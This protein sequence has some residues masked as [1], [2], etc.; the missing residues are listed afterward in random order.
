MV[1]FNGTV[2]DTQEKVLDADNRGFLYGDSVFETVKAVHQT[3]LF[4]E[5]HY[6]RLMASMRLM[7]M[8]IPMSFTLEFLRSELQK[9]IDPNHSHAT[10][11]RLSVFREPGGRYF[12]VSNE[13]QYLIVSE[14]LDVDAFVA[15]TSD[16]Q[17]DLFKD[18]H[19]TSSLLSTLKTNNRSLNV[20]G[21][22]YAQDN[23]L[24]NC[25]L[26]NEQKQVVEF[27]NGNLFIV[28]GT[29]IKTAPLSSGCIKGVIRKQLIQL[30]ENHTEYFFEEV[31]VSPFELQKADELWVT[32][33][34][35]GI[36][37][38][39]SYRKKSFGH[40]VALVFTE[41]LNELARKVD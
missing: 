24:D 40:K 28:Q 14:P 3:P 25:I 37:P 10:R 18:F 35:Q 34:V 23:D 22:R 39:G 20:I 12:P 2:L 38:V 36:R 16:Y 19:V 1:N 30:I 11:I 8:E 21:S 9:T 32:N 26:L 13:V 4:W 29:S 41:L 31:A 6:F 17:V 5:D 27:L 33:A 15:D 7:R